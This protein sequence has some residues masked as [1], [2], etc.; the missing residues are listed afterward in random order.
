M[1]KFLFIH[2]GR[3]GDMILMTGFLSQLKE[4]YPNSIINVIAGPSNAVILKNN[5]AIRKVIVL[6]K[7]PLGIAKFLKVILTESYDYY[8]DPKD[9]HSSEAQIIAKLVRSN[10]KVG[11][12]ASGSSPFDVSNTYG[13]NQNQYLHYS[14]LPFQAAKQLGIT[15]DNWKLTPK[16]YP[17]VENGK[18]VTTFLQNLNIFSSY[19]VLNIS[20]SNENKEWKIENW[21]KLKEQLLIVNLPI[22]IISSPKA[23]AKAKKLKD[24]GLPFVANFISNDLLDVIELIK[25]S[26]GVLTPDTSIVH[27]ASAFDKPLFGIYS[28]IDK[29]YQKFRPLNSN[30]IIVKG[31]ANTSGVQTV[32][33]KHSINEIP[34]FIKL[35]NTNTH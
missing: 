35:L 22:I 4:K 10:K 12:I 20:A 31:D 9:H 3:I 17:S 24:N 29:F 23:I 32:S 21:A 5:P 26:S 14:E 13:L 33:I 16:L 25:R 6:K 19:L 2:T 8:I 7:T 34:N 28:G 27:I 1:T 15:F 11:F 18:N 30:A